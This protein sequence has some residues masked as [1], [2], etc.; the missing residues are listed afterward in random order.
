MFAD[1]GLNPL[2]ISI[3]LMVCTGVSFLLEVPSGVLADKYSRKNILF[4]AELVRIVGY[5]FWLLMPNFLGFLIGFVFWGIK[6]AFTSGTFEALVYDE[7]KANNEEDKYIKIQGIVQCLHY[8]AYIFAGIGASLAISFGYSFVLLISMLSLLVSSISIFL[9]PKAKISQSTGEKKYF[10]LLKEGLTFSTKTPSVLSIMIFISL[11]QALFGA[12]DE[13]WSIFANQSG[14]TKQMLGIFFV[15]YG[16]VQAL[17]SVIA[18][19]F[20][21][22]SI[23]F[24]QFLFLLN[25]VLLVIAAYFYQVPSLLLLFAFSF[26]FKLIDTVTNSRLQHQIVLSNVRATITSVKEFFVELAAMGLFIL[27]GLLAKYINYQVAFMAVGGLIS[28]IGLYYL[29][30]VKD[31]S[32]VI[33][34]SD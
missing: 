12:L 13:Y 14:L 34:K 19:K 10:K 26:L 8:I 3:L 9:L 31:K 20:E 17:A 1:K 25:G 22:S 27:F 16:L 7:L 32:P 33:N 21:K 4:G 18:Y 2:Q 28:I 23:K 29:L 11:A 30:I 24:F 6:C 5:A 15:I